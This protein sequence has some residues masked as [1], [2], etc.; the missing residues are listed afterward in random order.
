MNKTKLIRLIFV[1]SMM[2]PVAFVYPQSNTTYDFLKL[3][4]GARA[5]ALGGS[6]T[7]STNDVNT[8]FY[9]PA[10]LSTLINRQ[11]SVGFSNI[12]LT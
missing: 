9:N 8:I 4:I 5:S 1:L 12:Y 2:V 7:S 11:A 10:A 6:F 3:D